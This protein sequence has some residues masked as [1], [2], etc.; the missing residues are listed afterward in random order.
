MSGHAILFFAPH[1]DLAAFTASGTLAALLARMPD[2]QVDIVCQQAHC[3]FYQ[4][5]PGHLRFHVVEARPKLGAR[6]ALAM[7]FMG[8]M[9]HRTIV[10]QGGV[11]PHLLW[12]RYRHY[13]DLPSDSYIACDAIDPTQQFGPQAFTPD[14]L[15]LPLPQ[16][17]QQTTP[18]IVFA[19]E[20]AT[21]ADW[22]A[23]HFAELAWRLTQ[24]GGAFA[25]AHYVLLDA[26]N[27][28]LATEI[29][30]NI[31]NGQITHLAD[32]PFVK[33]A[34][35][36]RRASAVIG[37]DRL[38]ARLAA[39]CKTPYVVRLDRQS[40]GGQRPYALYNGTESAPLADY[41]CAALAKTATKDGA[42]A[43]Q[44]QTSQ[45]PQNNQ[46]SGVGS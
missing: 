12:S 23:R 11:L 43:K 21:R 30:S 4:H 20:E 36:M 34:A 3:A 45:Q 27:S 15:H 31:P 37:T 8:R 5:A 39:A 41:L 44:N 22:Q 35:L 2:A 10:M 32:L 18:V 19:L 16:T 24:T 1:N 38:M 29:I 26:A 46:N 14:K 25:Q 6:L 13:I 28:P 9:W 40:D 17:L 7:K 33:R 42:S